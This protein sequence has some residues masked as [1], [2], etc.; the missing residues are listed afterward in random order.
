MSAEMY[1]E[2]IL[3][4][5]RRPRNH[6]TL[7]DADI[8]HEDDNPLCGDRVRV[9]VKIEDDRIADIRFQGKGCA[10]SQASASIMTDKVKGKTLDEVKAIDTDEV[11]GWLRIPVSP[12][13]VK[14]AMLGVKV[15]QAGIHQRER[16]Q[17]ESN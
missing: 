1:K 9:A 10:I 12:M 7:E 17:A 3:Q 16:E 4:H 5:F 13:R 2:Y 8:I 11:L 15:L 6:G 14:C